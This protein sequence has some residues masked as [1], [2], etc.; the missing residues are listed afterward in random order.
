MMSLRN[1][2]P[3][4]DGWRYY[5]GEGKPRVVPSG[6]LLCHNHVAHTVDGHNGANGFRFWICERVP[7]GFEPCRCGWAGLPH[8]SVIPDVPCLSRGARR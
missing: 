1:Y 6:F 5:K 8:Y 4:A 3:P 7:D 2:Y